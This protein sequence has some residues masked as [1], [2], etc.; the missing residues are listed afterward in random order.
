MSSK[1]RSTYITEI[2]REGMK[3]A[4]DSLDDHILVWLEPDLT[5]ETSNLHVSLG[6][7]TSARQVITFDDAQKCFDHLAKVPE[8]RVFL[9]LSFKIDDTQLQHFQ[10]LSNIEY[11]YAFGWDAI[12]KQEQSKLVLVTN[13]P[14]LIS[15]LSS[16]VR[17]S[18][19][20][21]DTDFVSLENVG[22]QSSPEF[23]MTGDAKLFIFYQLVLE[24]LLRY[25]KT[26]EIK[27]Q[28][29]S[30]CTDMIQGIPE[31]IKTWNE[32]LNT[33]NPSVAIRW[34]TR[35]CFLHRIFNHSCRIGDIKS[36][37]KLVFFMTDLYARLR[38]LHRCHFDLFS[39]HIYVY[40]G[41]PMSTGEFEKFTKSIGNL[42]V[43]KSFVSTTT[44]YDVARI[45]A[46]GYSE[47]SGI[48][49]AILKMK[50]DKQRN[51]SKPFCYIRGE[52]NVEDDDEVLMSIGMVFYLAEHSE[53]V[54]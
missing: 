16:D 36:M 48:L 19:G 17:A 21:E 4:E 25:P 3:I 42:V 50:I 13:I 9:V 18:Q 15:R 12:F 38:Y 31:E 2:P 24:I 7:Q 53:N 14:Q 26:P 47:V 34:Y 29:I 33:Y 8:Q 39:A 40:R 28:F 5:N 45:Y 20:D 54:Y 41:R 22:F 30:F 35:P 51:E 44:N 23:K 49:P 11:I 32:F 52:S 6:L 27:E 10:C 46:G 43:T 37:F 1:E